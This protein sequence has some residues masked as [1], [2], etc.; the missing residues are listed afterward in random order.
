MISYIRIATAVLFALFLSFYPTV[1]PFYAGTTIIIL[2]FVTDGLDGYFARKYDS[3]SKAGPFID[4][5]ADRIA[6]IVLL[7]PFTFIGI[8][9]PIIITYF[10]VKGLI[11]DYK[12]LLNFNS[13]SEV[14]FEQIRSKLGKFFLSSKFVRGI[15]G[16]AKLVM[17]LAFYSALFNSKFLDIANIL[18]ITS[19][20]ISLSRT[21]PTLFYKPK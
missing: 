15:Y 7:I 12:R 10:I 4:I 19:I 9:N 18:A 17:I 1:L 13:T 21:I 11:I 8:A 6:E 14:P 20:A 2:I 5:L 3:P 16:I